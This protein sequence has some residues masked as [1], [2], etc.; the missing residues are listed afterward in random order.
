[1]PE[2]IE[3]PVDLECAWKL[4]I[5]V[6]DAASDTDKIVHIIYH[7]DNEPSKPVFFGSG[8]GHM[9]GLERIDDGSWRTNIQMKA[10]E[11][12][13]FSMHI[14]MPEGPPDFDK[15]QHFKSQKRIYRPDGSFSEPLPE[16]YEKK[17]G[18]ELVDIYLPADYTLVKKI[19]SGVTPFQTTPK[20]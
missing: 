9:V 11:S 10:N 18:E 16:E 1:M 4:G 13:E 5:Q 7:P 19:K 20:S 15:P 6:A 12:R 2:K 8:E 3:I 17:P 14:G